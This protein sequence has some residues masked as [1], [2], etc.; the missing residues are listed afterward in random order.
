MEKIDNFR[1]PG[2]QCTEDENDEDIG[3]NIKKTK[4]GIVTTLL[5]MI[6]FDVDEEY[7]VIGHHH[8]VKTKNKLKRLVVKIPWITYRKGFKPLDEFR[9]DHGWGCMI[10]VAQMMLA[11]TLIRH[12]Q[13]R[14]INLNIQEHMKTI[15]PLFLDDYTKGDAPF[16]IHN[17]IEI[18]KRILNKGSGEWYGAHSISQ[19]IR[20]ANE[21]YNYQYSREFHILTF[22]E[23]VIYKN[24]FNYEDH[25]EEV[26]YLVTVPLRLGLN[27]VDE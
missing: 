1:A 23:G 18:G 17:I 22:N 4:I 5:R 19:V 14:L 12:N 24:E 27:K 13:Y 10:R 3:Y 26:S 11:N 15:L 16:G 7:R 20:E 21:L 6:G 25:K 2:I 9:S 8:S